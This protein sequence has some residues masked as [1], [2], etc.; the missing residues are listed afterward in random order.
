MVSSKVHQRTLWPSSK[1]LSNQQRVIEGGRVCVYVCV[2]GKP[3]IADGCVQ[4]KW[5]ILKMATSQDRMLCKCPETMGVG[6]ICILNISISLVGHSVPGGS[7]KTQKVENG[8][9]T[10]TSGVSQFS[11][12]IEHI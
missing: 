5:K 4:K 1:V 7:Q 10:G 6:V 8:I 2:C 3:K 12:S 9:H 11:N